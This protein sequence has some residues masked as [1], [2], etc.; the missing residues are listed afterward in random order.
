MGIPEFRLAPL[1]ITISAGNMLPKFAC[2]AFNRIINKRSR[3]NENE[4]ERN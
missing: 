1:K 4:L 3:K 2:T